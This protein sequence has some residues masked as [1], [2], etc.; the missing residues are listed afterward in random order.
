[1]SDD[2]TRLEFAVATALCCRFLRLNKT[3]QR[4][5]AATARKH[6][7]GLGRKRVLAFKYKHLL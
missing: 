1:M 7:G 3:R 6:C 4:S 5:D 2:M